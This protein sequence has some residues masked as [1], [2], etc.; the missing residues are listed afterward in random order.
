MSLAL[1]EEWLDLMTNLEES[2]GV[3]EAHP[4]QISHEDD[5]FASRV[6]LLEI[7]K[8]LARLAHL[9][10]SIDNRLHLPG[11]DE[12]LD[13]EQTPV[14]SAPRA[15]AIC[16]AKVP[17]PPEAPLIRTFCPGCTSA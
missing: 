3:M 13:I 16:T 11:F 6:L 5:D 2:V 4:C 7:S 8:C 9:V 10:G 15:F 12:T 17:T 14:T 1:E